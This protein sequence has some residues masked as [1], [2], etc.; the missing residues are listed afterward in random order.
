MASFSKTWLLRVSCAFLELVLGVIYSAVL[1]WISNLWGLFASALPWVILLA[2]RRRI[3]RYLRSLLLI[4]VGLLPIMLIASLLFHTTTFFYLI[5]IRAAVFA[6]IAASTIRTEALEGLILA[7][8]GRARALATSIA[9]AMR[10]LASSE[11]EVRETV[12]ALRARG[13][14]L[15]RHAWRHLPTVLTGV[16]VPC[17]STSVS[18]AIDSVTTVQHLSAKQLRAHIL[19]SKR[20]AIRMIALALPLLL[21]ICFE[22]NLI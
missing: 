21:A 12:E 13:I 4:F 10:L 18:Y 14:A 8:R 1:V 15:D 7:T 5:P 19:V 20:C 16:L 9:F 22:L 3:E 2:T 6:V 11:R 17:F